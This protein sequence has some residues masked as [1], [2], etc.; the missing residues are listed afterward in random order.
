[1]SLKKYKSQG[2]AVEV[3]F[4]WISSRIRPLYSRSVTDAT[5]ELD[6]HMA[7]ISDD[8]SR[9]VFVSA[10]FFIATR[11]IGHSIARKEQP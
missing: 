3:T 5:G 1:M 7:K 6:S 8:L 9:S 4:V 10:I 11:F 2:K